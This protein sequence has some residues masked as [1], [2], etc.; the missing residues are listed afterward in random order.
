MISGCHVISL[1][2]NTGQSE[3]VYQ[4]NEACQ[5]QGGIQKSPILRADLTVTISLEKWLLWR[6]DYIALYSIR[7]PPQI[8]L[9]PHFTP[10]F[11]GISKPGV[12]NPFSKQQKMIDST[13]FLILMDLILVHHCPPDQD[14]Y[15]IWIPNPPDKLKGP[16]PALQLL[17]KGPACLRNKKDAFS[18]SIV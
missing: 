1:C 5:P 18:A 10:K 13:V 6:M 3:C 15:S 9:S 17:P 8:L 7:I 4:S 12:G 16:L 11:P 14:I 2:S